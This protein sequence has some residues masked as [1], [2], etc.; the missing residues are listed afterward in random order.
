VEVHPVLLKVTIE[1]RSQTATEME[2][3]EH[4]LTVAHY[5]SLT[6]EPALLG[7]CQESRYSALRMYKRT[8]LATN[9]L[10]DSVYFQYEVDTMYLGKKV[11]DRFTRRSEFVWDPPRPGNFGRG[12]RYITIDEMRK[13]DP[14]DLGVGKPGWAT[15]R[16]LRSL[17]LDAA[18]MLEPLRD[19]R[20]LGM[21]LCRASI[22]DL[23]VGMARMFKTF[24]EWRFLSEVV[25]VLHF[26]E[27][28]RE[29][30]RKWEGKGEEGETPLEILRDEAREHMKRHL[31]FVES[32]WHDGA[33]HLREHIAA[34]GRNYSKMPA[35]AVL[36]LHV[37]EKRCPKVSILYQQAGRRA[38]SEG[39]EW[40]EWEK[41]LNTP[42]LPCEREDCR[43]FLSLN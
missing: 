10:P 13:D 33:D 25:F 11:M 29:Q 39:V 37:K 3:E 1:R 20:G 24:M 22:R 2:M 35:S 26:R 8:A 28:D 16:P 9:F 12:E 15:L 19:Y 42:V 4:D 17:A 23:C 32:Y 36:W 21:H 27:Q 14:L 18:W 43:R 40:Q 5:W 6:P 41:V 34:C 30:V 7:T 31:E 38:S